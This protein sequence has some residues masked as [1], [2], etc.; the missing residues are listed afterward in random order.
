[1]I[2][3]LT[4]CTLLSAAAYASDSNSSA[5]V[6]DDVQPDASLTLEGGGVAPGI[7]YIW[8]HGELEYQNSSRRFSIEGV[9]LVDVGATDFSASGYVYNLQMLEDFSGNY[10]AAGAGVTVAG[11]GTGPYLRNE[12]GVIIKLTATDA[13]MKFTLSAEGMHVALQK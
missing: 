8:G 6:A 13:G 5:P 3:A 9:A 7:G 2:I 11:G 4:A 12:P 1:M 10:V